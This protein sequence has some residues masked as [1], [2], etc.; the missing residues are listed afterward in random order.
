MYVQRLIN[1]LDDVGELQDGALNSWLSESEVV[2]NVRKQFRETPER[3]RLDLLEDLDRNVFNG[4]CVGVSSETALEE[5]REKR[6]DQIVDT[7][8]VS[9]GRI[10]H[11]PEKQCSFHASLNS[12]M[13]EEE[14]T[15]MRARNVDAQLS[16][17]LA[18]LNGQSFFLV[19]VL[20]EFL[21]FAALLGENV[22]DAL[23]IDGEVSEDDSPGV[24][25]NG[26]RTALGHAAPEQLLQFV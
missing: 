9:A 19:V 8:D 6:S 11:G 21:V 20:E 24:A 14:A 15:R 13:A 1:S 22:S 12:R 18:F 23:A 2:L 10:L 17:Q 16:Q 5:D 4:N 25:A 3:I 7:L 26:G